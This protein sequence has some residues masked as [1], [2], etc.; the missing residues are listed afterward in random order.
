M[1]Q[2]H[3]EL[4]KDEPVLMDIA[5]II[6]QDVGM[7]ALILQTINSSFF[8]LRTKM[9]YSACCQPAWYNLCHQYRNGIVVKAHFR[10]VRRCKST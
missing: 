3:Q 7:S 1:K 8:G 4:Q 10:G 5:N 6:S 9:F 2:L